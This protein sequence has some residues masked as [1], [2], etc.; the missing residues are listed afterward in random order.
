ML[1]PLPISDCFRRGCPIIHA[2]PVC[3]R[4]QLNG[5]KSDQLSFLHLW[6]HSTI[7]VVWGWVVNTWPTENSSA[8]YAYGAWINSCIHVIMYAYYGLTAMNIRPPTWAKK[9]VTTAQRVIEKQRERQLSQ[10]SSRAGRLI[11]RIL[12]QQQEDA[13][14]AAR[15]HLL[16]KKRRGTLS[17]QEKGRNSY[18]RAI[19]KYMKTNKCS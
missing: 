14:K 3:T 8:A 9:S 17:E 5:K 16:E 13:E 4:S 19:R 12:L 15:K 11:G 10:L 2:L 18:R 6:H 1:Q 7:V